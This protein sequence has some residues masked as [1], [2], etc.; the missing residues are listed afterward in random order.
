MKERTRFAPSPTGMLHIGG[1]RTALWAYFL[2]RQTDGAFVLRIEDTDQARTVEGGIQNIVETLE[3]VGIAPDE[4]F[5]MG[6]NGVEEHG[7]LGPY[8]QSERL[9]LYTRYAQQLID[10]GHAYRCFCTKERLDMLRKGQQ[11]RGEQTRYDRH[12]LNL[13]D[14]E[15]TKRLGD[16]H[17]VRMRVPEG[18]TTFTDIVRGKVTFQHA[19]IDDQVILKSDGFPTY[20]LAVVVDDH[21]MEITT[22]IRGEEWL[23]STPK[24]L[25]LYKF[26]GF[27][28][29][30]FAHVPLLL[31]S[32]K[33]KL[34]KR[35]GDVAADSYLE[36][37]YL[38]E[39]LVNFIATLGYNPTGDR[40]LY[41]QDELI[42]LFD[43][44]RV[45]KSGAVV[46]FE[47]LDWM[48]KQYLSQMATNDVLRR[49]AGLG[50][51]GIDE[52]VIEVEKHRAT[53]LF[54]IVEA[55]KQYKDTP[56][57]DAHILVWKKSDAA[58]ARNMLMTA[59]D[60]LDGLDTEQPCS[61]LEETMKTWIKEQG[62][63]TGAILWPL[64]VALSGAERSASP[65]EYIYIL[66][67]DEA[68]KRIQTAIEKL[69]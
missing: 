2:A 27:D 64:R 32:D 13:S 62:I 19:E 8:K 16:Q 40:E 58:D 18:E 3:R 21:H 52:N 68:Q 46:N 5:R 66:G 69:T 39:A 44:S 50:E 51:Q 15:I 45:K 41:A 6:S 9:E 35:Q 26:L 34:S 30:K 25:I 22:V 59:R 36:R 49:L 37:G 12:C 29:P 31:N 38:P 65:F 11:E 42:K 7:S 28:A 23:T 56:D 54:E 1:L 57:Y 67:K 53:T 63:Q 10:T 43:L 24:H 55:A 61:I 20:H 17:V 4:G 47:K 14:D 33:S 48:N 60:Y